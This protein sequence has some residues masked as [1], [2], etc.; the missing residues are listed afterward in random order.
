VGKRTRSFFEKEAEA[1][2]YA[3]AKN[4]ELHNKGIEAINFPTRLRQIAQECDALLKE[5]QRT[6][7]EATEFYLAS[8]LVPSAVLKSGRPPSSARALGESVEHARARAMRRKPSRNGDRLI[9]VGRG[10]VAGAK[11]FRRYIGISLFSRW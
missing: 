5:H 11:R 6:L 8:A 7:K 1:K 2:S 4:I 10:R 3:Q 9:D